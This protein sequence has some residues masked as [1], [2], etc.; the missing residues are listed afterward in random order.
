MVQGEK[1]IDCSIP[2]WSSRPKVRIE[3]LEETRRICMTIYHMRNVCISLHKFGSNYDIDFPSAD[4]LFPWFRRQMSQPLTELET[5][6]TSTLIMH[7]V[8]TRYYLGFCLQTGP[9][10]GGTLPACE[11]PRSIDLSCGFVGRWFGLN[12]S[13]IEI[14]GAS[15]NWVS[16]TMILKYW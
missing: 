15:A 13:K 6:E 11:D 7:S 5:M 1:R 2:L 14:D 3:N 10:F 4:H 9:D 8:Q 12:D 16:S